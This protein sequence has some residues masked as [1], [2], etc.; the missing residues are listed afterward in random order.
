MPQGAIHGDAVNVSKTGAGVE[1][2]YG[3]TRSNTALGLDD[4]EVPY[5]A[6]SD[7]LRMWEEA[8]AVHRVSWYC[9]GVGLTKRIIGGPNTSALWELVDCVGCPDQPDE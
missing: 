9:P 8:D 4:V 5:G 7:C 3:A 2:Q 1:I 6:F